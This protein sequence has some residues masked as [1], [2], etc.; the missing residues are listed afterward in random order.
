[1]I[2]YR[3]KTGLTLI[4]LLVALAL[5]AVVT[6]IVTK[7]FMNV[8]DVQRR[9]YQ[10]QNLEGDLRYAVNVLSDEAQRAKIHS[11]ECD[12]YC[13]ACS[14]KFFCLGISTSSVVCLAAQDNSCVQYYQSNGQLIVQ[15]GAQTY[16]ITS[17]DVT[18]ESLVFKH[19]LLDAA[20]N[21]NSLEIFARVKNK[22]AGGGSLV[23]QTALT[24][25]P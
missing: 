10:D 19:D 24:K 4:E 7:V 6:L 11:T 23:Y 5:F 18:L 2:T 21:G 15:R 22:D 12:S 20:Q 1:M 3:T 16:A 13:T 14:G 9:I 25:N 8:T 17:S